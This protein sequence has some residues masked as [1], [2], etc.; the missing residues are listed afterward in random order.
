MRDL[1]FLALPVVALLG[2][3]MLAPGTVPA[4]ASIMAPFPGGAQPVNVNV[5]FNTQV[6]LPD[7]SEETLS[8]AQKAGREYVYALGS[9]ECTLLL[10]TIA[11]TCRLTNLNVNTQVQQ[12]H[13]HNAV[14]PLLNIN[15]NA[16]FQITLKPA[17]GGE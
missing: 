13:R 8:A 17:A 14:Q 2:G 7:L 3:L 9:G 11:E 15:G 5:G 1:R 4:K 16:N 10:A 12:Q 6:P